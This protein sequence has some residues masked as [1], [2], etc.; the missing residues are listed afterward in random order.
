MG[1]L[2]ADA[3]GSNVDA[4]CP[5]FL[6]RWVGGTYLV[7]GVFPITRSHLTVNGMESRVDE[8]YAATKSRKRGIWP[9][10][11]CAYYL[12]PIYS[13]PNFPDDVV[14]WVHHRHSYQWAIWHEP[15][16]Y[17]CA[18]NVAHMRSDYGMFGAAFRPYL[19]SVIWG[20]LFG[21]ARRNGCEHP[22]RMN[23]QDVHIEPL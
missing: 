10:G 11:I 12:I 3:G 8:F 23:G 13:C 9:R 17:A 14:D 1:I 7:T 20:G 15:V 16:L 19:L 18:D 6:E 22:S 21:A 4:E 5:T 2:K